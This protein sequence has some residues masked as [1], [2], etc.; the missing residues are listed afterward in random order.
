[1]DEDA[2]KNVTV[3]LALWP[4]FTLNQ[5]Q[6]GTTANNLNLQFSLAKDAP[7]GRTGRK[8]VKQGDM[9]EV[10]LS[11]DVTG[12]DDSAS[13][14]V[15]KW[16][17]LQESTVIG[18]D[19]QLE[20]KV[21][22]VASGSQKSVLG[23]KVYKPDNKG[24]T[25]LKYSA[26]KTGEEEVELSVTPYNMNS[27]VIYT[28]YKKRVNAGVDESLTPEAGSWIKELEY[29]YTQGDSTTQ[30]IPIAISKAVEQEYKI[31]A[32]LENQSRSFISQRLYFD[33]TEVQAPPKVTQI[34]NVD[35]IYVVPGTVSEGN[36]TPQ[37]DAIGFDIEWNA[38]KLDELNSLLNKGSLYYELLIRNT[39]D[40]AETPTLI[41][42][43]EIS[44]VTSGAITTSSAIKVVTYAG[45]AGGIKQEGVYYTTLGTFEMPKVVL[46]SPRKEGWEKINVTDAYPYKLITDYPTH[47][48]TDDL[49]NTVPGTYYLSMR[50]ILKEDGG[51]LVCS[52]DESNLVA[53]SLDDVN[54]VL[55][56]VDTISSQKN[57]ELTDEAGN[58]L[59]AQD[60]FFNDVDIT[61]YVDNMLEVADWHVYDKDDM[62]NTL[63]KGKYEIF[64]YTEKANGSGYSESDFDAVIKKNGYKASEAGSTNKFDF[65]SDIDQLRKGE[66]IAI[67]YNKN[68]MQG[69]GPDTELNFTNLDPNQV[70]YVRMRVKV[71]PWREALDGT[72]EYQ[73]GKRNTSTLSKVHSFTTNTKPVPPVPDDKV[74]P[75]PESFF[76]KDQPN[77]TTAILGW[78]KAKL[79]KEEDITAIYYELVRSNDIRLTA[80]QLKNNVDFIDL[81]KNNNYMTG[82]NT[83]DAYIKKYTKDNLAGIELVPQ[84]LSSEFLLTDDSLSP[85]AVY[86]YY[87]RTVCEIDGEKVKSQWLMVP[88]TTSPVAPPIHLKVETVKNY[89]HN[90][91]N[92]IVISFDAPVPPGAK[93][94]EEYEFEIAVQGE[95]DSEYSSS[96]YSVQKVTSNQNDDLTSEGYTHFVYKISGLKPNKRYDIKVRIKDKTKPLVS[97]GS[98]PT[99]LYSDKVTTRTE[100]DED[101]QIKD[102]KYEEYLKKF[103]SEVEKLRRRPYWTVETGMTYKYRASY[104]NTEISF[105]NQYE[106]VVGGSDAEEAY[107]YMPA[108]MLDEASSM[109]TVLQVV[110][111]NETIN[112]RPYTLTTANDDIASAISLINANKLEDYYVA[113][114][115]S[116]YKRTGTINGETVL[117]PE[118]ALDMKLVYMEK[119]DMIIEDDIMIE[120]NTL[121]D[122][123][124]IR[125]IEKLEKKINN[126]VIAD[127]V[128]STIITESVSNIEEAHPEKVERLLKRYNSK[129]VSINKIEKPILITTQLDSYAV[130]GY[131]YEDKWK[132]VD[133][134]LVGNGFALEGAVL[135]SY[136]FTGQK[137]LI[138]TVPALAPYQNMIGK[139]NLTDFFTLN[140]YMIKTA[141]T[142]EQVYGSVA[143]LI[144]ASRGTDYVVY[145]KNNGI[146]GVT[147][148]GLNKGMRQDEAIYII[149]QAY[150]K[151]HNRPITAIVIN[152][153]Q[154]VQNIGAFQAQHRNYVYAAVELKVTTPTNAKVLPSKE[155]NVEEVIK[156]LYK[157]QAQ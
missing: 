30:T 137:S 58:Q 3:S 92:E 65:S 42:T 144:G 113:M 55:P 14:Y 152:N 132:Q 27:K 47:T 104:V 85:N 67:E 149:M 133:T 36:K 94:P 26:S 88:V 77:N 147:S 54:I 17:K 125:F 153:K 33:P 107:Y 93:V 28:V 135:G 121:I 124:R 97:G 59:I 154:S 69:K 141:A 57:T 32:R 71:E 95:L 139:Y 118:I 70:Y 114:H 15:I 155:M 37:P 1:M 73:T 101:E 11:Q 99:S 122:R 64:L 16:D 22:D 84:Q 13:P 142:K 87:I 115:F 46:K 110:L 49:Y 40:G 45:T 56:T 18:G 44:K 10:Y 8:V 62:E 24:Y 60:V 31:E 116:T 72:I 21:D 34:V 96:K 9:I 48:V 38:P 43:F 100:Y 150:E 5:G 111:G 151:I 145:L 52:P 68:N 78:E 128:L 102:D 91:K 29:I 138:D 89:N 19:I 75:A 23:E 126:G 83:K 66:I 41:K 90:P 108:N 148:I 80:E 103:D 61:K 134:Y 129:T 79:E 63:Y 112:I 12:L 119:E 127:D 6:G 106:L 105:K 156:M 76:L 4:E 146:K 157:V 130:N 2:A 53:I 39:K 51:V 7:I 81:I 74:P 35:N 86:Y 109:K 82:F 117:T 25:Y 98:Y 120:L 140:N 50:S 123:E 20:V 131:Y 143:R 136:I